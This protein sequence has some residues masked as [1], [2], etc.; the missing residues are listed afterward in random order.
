MT[1]RTT[2]RKSPPRPQDDHEIRRRRPPVD[3]SAFRDRID[4]D[5]F[6]R[7]ASEADLQAAE[8]DLSE[9]VAPAS[10]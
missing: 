4:P 7:P 2:V 5:L 8:G 10:K 6:L 3:W 9:F 1:N